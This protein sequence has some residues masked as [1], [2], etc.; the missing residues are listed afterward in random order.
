MTLVFTMNR[1]HIWFREGSNCLGDL[2]FAIFLRLCKINVRR[3]LFQLAPGY[4]G[5]LLKHLLLVLSF[6]Q[7]RPHL[8]C[9][10]VHPYQLDELISNFRGVLHH[11][12]LIFYIISC[13]RSAALDL[14]LHCFPMSQ[15]MER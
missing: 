4:N 12:Y 1:N 6:F 7:I 2:N 10:P 13:K 14:G 9:G 5:N 15:K 3:F 11:F 8:S